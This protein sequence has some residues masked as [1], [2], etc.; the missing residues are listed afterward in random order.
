MLESLPL[1]D[2]QLRRPIHEELHSR[3]HQQQPHNPYLD[4]NPRSPITCRTRPAAAAKTKYLITH[5]TAIGPRIAP[6]SQ[7][8]SEGA[9][10]TI[11][12]TVTEE[13]APGLPAWDF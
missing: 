1:N 2:A 3:R 12:V 5:V 7:F 4:T 8:H 9:C 6:I 11:T 10:P 13:I